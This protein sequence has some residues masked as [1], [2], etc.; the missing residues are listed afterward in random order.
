MCVYASAQQNAAATLNRNQELSASAPEF[1]P[2]FKPTPPISGDW[3]YQA[4]H[5]ETSQVYPPHIYQP[6]NHSRPFQQQQQP[7]QQYHRNYS[8]YPQQQQ[9]SNRNFRPDLIQNHHPSYSNHHQQHHPQQQQQQQQHYMMMN[10]QPHANFQQQAH[11]GGGHEGGGGHGR[12]SGIQN[13]L[14]FQNSHQPEPVHEPV[15]HKQVNFYNFLIIRMLLNFSLQT[16]TEQVALDYL[17][18]MMT[19]LND[20]PGLFENYQKK[21]REMFLE[22]SN[23]HFVMSNAIETIFEQVK[24]IISQ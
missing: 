7:Q 3:N 15:P 24:L 16:E 8:A 19:K 10:Q 14:N 18:E 5:Q 11:S 1:I 20:N 9:Q 21:L 13:R 17:S 2:N 23:N 22:L 4:H 12:G 6:Q